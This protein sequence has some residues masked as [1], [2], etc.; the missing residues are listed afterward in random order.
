MPSSLN[1][2]LACAAVTN[3]A[4]QLFLNLNHKNVVFSK[5]VIFESIIDVC[6]AIIEKENN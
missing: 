2:T 5:R 6:I 3:I 4:H 1:K